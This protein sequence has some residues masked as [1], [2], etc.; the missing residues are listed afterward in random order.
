LYLEAV[1]LHKEIEDDFGRLFLKLTK[2]ITTLLAKQ[3]P[4]ISEEKFYAGFSCDCFRGVLDGLVTSL[5]AVGSRK[6]IDDNYD[7]AISILF[8]QMIGPLNRI[9]LPDGIEQNKLCFGYLSIMDKALQQVPVRSRFTGILEQ[10]LK[11]A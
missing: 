1:E 2:G 11:A 7:E 10:A 9:S 4:G 3:F 5:H 6:E 8:I